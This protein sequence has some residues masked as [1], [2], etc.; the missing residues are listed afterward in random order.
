MAGKAARGHEPE[1]PPSLWLA[2]AAE[3]LRIINKLADRFG[4]G[5]VILLLLL[6]TIWG[7][8]DSTT[9]NDFVRYLVFGEVGRD[10][11]VRFLALFLVLDVV[12]GIT[13][14]IRYSVGERREMRRIA[15]E[16]AKWQSRALGVELNHTNGEEE[17]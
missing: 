7:F 4:M 6:V 16:K 10:A 3:S 14:G 11:A 17:G 12:L 9:K 15:A 13:A 1:S 8:G 5:L 2:I